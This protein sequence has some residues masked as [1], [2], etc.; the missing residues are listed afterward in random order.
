MQPPGKTLIRP[1]LHM[2]ILPPS[3]IVH[4][5]LKLKDLSKGS[6]LNTSIPYRITSESGSHD[7]YLRMSRKS[8]FKAHKVACV[9]PSGVF[10]CIK[11]IACASSPQSQ[12]PKLKESS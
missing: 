9:K 12:I 7:L 10:N 8:K 4:S 1:K 5:N 2:G 3:A 6:F 11:L